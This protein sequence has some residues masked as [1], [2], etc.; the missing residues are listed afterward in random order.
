[1]TVRAMMRRL[2]GLVLTILIASTLS[3]FV[4]NILPG[5]PAQVIV[6]LEGSPESLQA[7]RAELGLNRPLGVRFGAWLGGLA[8]GDLGRSIHYQQSVLSL[9]VGRLPLTAVLAAL[10]I[11]I[12]A[13]I[14]VPLGV[15]AAARR[16]QAV[17]W[18]ATLFL[19]LGLAIPAF[20]LGILGI[21]AFSLGLRLLPPGGYAGSGEGFFTGL[22][23]LVLPALTLAVGRAAVLTRLTR[24]SMNEALSANFIQ[25]A[26]GKGVPEGRVLFRHGLRN[27]V[28]PVLT[29][30]GLQVGALLAGSVVV[31]RVFALPGLG[32]LLLMGVSNRDLP[33]VQGLVVFFVTIVSLV[34]LAVDLSYGAIDP[35]TRAGEVAQ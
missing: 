23:Y 10:A 34:N 22:G 19:Q 30:A 6:G 18:W 17:D 8:R 4:F 15:L 32:T 13:A 3:F 35:R 27:A 31:E 1:M 14:G 33:L 28:I 26:R 24:A 16:G 25:A 11:L 12:A 9:I 5:D 29:S 20:W 21:M 2:A 7:V